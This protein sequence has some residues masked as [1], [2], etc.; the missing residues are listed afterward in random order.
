MCEQVLQRLKLLGQLL[1]HA[2]AL[3]LIARIGQMPER[4][5]L[6]VEGNRDRIGRGLA[7]QFF[8]HSEKAVNRVGKLPLLGGEQLNTV[9][10]AV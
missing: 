10:G 9:K 1:G 2:L 5:G 3:G 7:F 4:G 6:Q 8:K